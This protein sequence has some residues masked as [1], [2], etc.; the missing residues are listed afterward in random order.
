[1]SVAVFDDTTMCFNVKTKWCIIYQSQSQTPV[2]E[3][4]YL[5]LQNWTIWLTFSRV[6][7]LTR[8]KQTL[9][10]NCTTNENDSKDDKLNHSLSFIF[11]EVNLGRI[12]KA[13]LS[14]S[15][16]RPKLCQ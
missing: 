8:I 9:S 12:I 3:Q 6:V 10:K 2:I 4:T 14:W 16:T 13:Y 7:G 5:I 15:R 1:M 11:E